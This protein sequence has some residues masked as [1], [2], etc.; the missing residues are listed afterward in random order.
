VIS[1]TGISSLIGQTEGTIYMEIN[2]NNI[3]NSAGRLLYTIYNNSTNARISSGIGTNN[4]IDLFVT[5]PPNTQTFSQT[6]SKGKLKLAVSYKNSNI[7]LTVNGVLS[8]AITTLNVPASMNSLMLGAVF[9]GTFQ[10]GEGIDL[11]AHWKTALTDQE[12]I[13]LTT[14]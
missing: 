2:V 6:I 11:F 4:K 8:T 10:L 5:G 9:N 7:F 12:C 3:S 1:K 14:I 13:N